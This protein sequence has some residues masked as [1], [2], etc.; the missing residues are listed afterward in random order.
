MKSVLLIFAGGGLGSVARFLLGKWV[1]SFHH[2]NF[3]FGT[4]AVNVMACFILGVV[5]GLSD[6]KQ[7]LSADSRIFWAI[8]F[9][10]G[11][12]TF[13]TFSYETLQLVNGQAIGSGML[14]VALSVVACLG[15]V[16]LGLYVG[17]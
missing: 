13:S 5:V 6:S 12:S 10:G 2:V 16:A 3:P 14:Y 15:A 17:K 11:F 9:C 1:S 8:G 4:L 7:L